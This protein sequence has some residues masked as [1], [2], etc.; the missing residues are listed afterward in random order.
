M[1]RKATYDQDKVKGL[2][3]SIIDAAQL[4]MNDDPKVDSWSQYKKELILRMAP[5]AL[6]Q[7]NAGRDD[8]ERLYPKPLLG[9]KSNG[10]SNNSDQETSETDESD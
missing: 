3:M 4:V 2:R 1:A 8:D 7:L 5:R 6:P 9:G 10:E